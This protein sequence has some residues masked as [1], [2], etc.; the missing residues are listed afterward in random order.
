MTHAYE[1]LI[2]APHEAPRYARL[3]YGTYAYLLSDPTTLCVVALHRGQPVGLVVGAAHPSL[4]F[5]KLLSVF[6]EAAHR[7]RG[8]ATRLVLM[9]EAQ[10]R[11]QGDTLLKA[12]YAAPKPAVE[13]LLRRCGWQ[14]PQHTMDILQAPFAAL[15]DLIT[16][17][18]LPPPP[19]NAQFFPW[20]QRSPR[21]LET[22][23]AR[24]VEFGEALHPE[25]DNTPLEAGSTGLRINDQL[26]GWAI[27][28]PITSEMVRCSAL[29]LFKEARQ[30]GVWQHLV[31]AAYERQ[32]AAHPYRTMVLPCVLPFAR[33]L[34]S[35][36][37]ARLQTTQPYHEAAKPL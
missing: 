21:D 33:L 34:K 8:V 16:R 27:L 3:T 29:F 6:V 26:A 36:L 19:A 17:T 22:L 15:D 28:H 35:Y 32:M 18:P 25:L 2:P 30:P 31:R 24:A 4:A 5:T 1:Y 13:G 14:P 10:A 12:S 37:G 23:A 9:L 7:R 20:E 11:Q